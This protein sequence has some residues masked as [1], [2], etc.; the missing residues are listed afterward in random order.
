MRADLIFKGDDV[1]FCP[2]TQQDQVSGVRKGGQT[3]DA[4]CL[5]VPVA[6]SCQRVG[7]VQLF[8][9]VLGGQSA[10]LIHHDGLVAFVA[11]HQ[12]DTGVFD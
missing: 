1:V 9:D 12:S 8:Q 11:D 6:E 10:V 5:C 2:G 3:V 4:R 7:A